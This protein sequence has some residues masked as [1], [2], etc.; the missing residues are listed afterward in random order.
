MDNL[1]I[2]F[3]Y[4]KHFL[5]AFT[6]TLLLSTVFIGYI[7]KSKIFSRFIDIPN[8][9]SLHIK[10]KS[11][12]GGLAIIISIII[13]ILLYN[14]QFIYLIPFLL[15]LLFLSF[16]DDLIVIKPSI[17]LAVQFLTTFIFLTIL[18]L[19]LSYLLLITFLFVLVWI[20]NL[21]NFMDGSDG[22]ATGMSIIGFSFYAIISILAGEV[23]FAILNTIIVAGCISFLFFNYPPAKIFMGD[24]GSIPLGFLC[25][26]V[27]IIGWQKLLWPLWLPI[28]IFSPFIID[29]TTTLIKR[30][31]NKESLTQ[32]HR[33]HYYQRAILSGYSHKQIALFSYFLMIFSGLVGLIALTTDNNKIITFMFILLFFC[34]VLIMR[35]VDIIWAKYLVSHQNNE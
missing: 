8:H 35:F 14:F 31:I 3:L 30:L 19:Q 29:A 4:S 15:V 23:D 10:P 12:I 34:F 27:G 25:G 26:A 28:I 24:T 32:A 20:I 5:F 16:L 1:F 9:R 17:R 21:Y 7:L 13:S 2:S 33:S 11:K 22:L 6:T 18:N